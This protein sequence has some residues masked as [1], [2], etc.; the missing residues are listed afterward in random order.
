MQFVYA[1][2]V[3]AF[4]HKAIPPHWKRGIVGVGHATRVRRKVCRGNSRKRAKH[5]KAK[6]TRRHHHGNRIARQTQNQTRRNCA[7]RRPRRGEH[8]PAWPL[9]KFVKDCARA[10]SRGN[11]RH[12]IF[13]AH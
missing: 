3:H 5:F 9:R 13:V 2:G 12:K 8:R 6:S 10:Q 11:L 4:A 7:N 1:V